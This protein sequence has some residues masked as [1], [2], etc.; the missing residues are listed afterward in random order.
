MYLLGMKEEW[1]AL[2]AGTGGTGDPGTTKP[3]T[4]ETEAARERVGGGVE[5]T[6]A[7]E[8]DVIARDV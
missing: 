2:G 5:T 7:A 1:V 8:E 3:F 6:D 4:V